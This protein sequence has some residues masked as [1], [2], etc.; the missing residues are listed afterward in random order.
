MSA[1]PIIEFEADIKLGSCELRIIA[2]RKIETIKLND[3][4]VE[5]PIALQDGTNI[6]VIPL[7]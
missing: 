7:E 4:N 5:F 2:S 1:K 3:D 6:L